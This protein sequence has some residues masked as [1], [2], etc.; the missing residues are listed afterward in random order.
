VCDQVAGKQ[1][2]AENRCSEIWLLQSQI[3]QIWSMK[4]AL[5]KYHNN[6]MH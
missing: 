1:D 6:I 4:K 3:L 5:G 2:D